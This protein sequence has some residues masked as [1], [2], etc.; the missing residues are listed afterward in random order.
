[1]LTATFKITAKD[2]SSSRATFIFEPLEKG[3]GHT[4]GNSLRRAMLNSLPGSA[5]T[6]I[7]IKGVRHQFSNLKG[8]SEDI[9][10]FI[11]NLRI[12]ELSQH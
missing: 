8:M 11:L 3:Y 7:K 10:E 1:M 9:V 12:K 6:Q 5:I 2:T 4:L